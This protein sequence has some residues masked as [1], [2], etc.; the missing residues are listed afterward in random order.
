MGKTFADTTG[1]RNGM[2]LNAKEDGAS[3]GMPIQNAN[4]FVEFST[5]DKMRRGAEPQIFDNNGSTSKADGGG[6]VES[7]YQG[8]ISYGAP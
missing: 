1:N 2:I 3:I 4:P 7:G 6:V 8:P 5:G